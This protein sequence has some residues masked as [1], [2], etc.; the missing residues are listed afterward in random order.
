MA[1]TKYIK[2]PIVRS[3]ASYVDQELRKIE[4]AINSLAA[5]SGDTAPL[6]VKKTADTSRAST[7]TL[8]A[9]PDLVLTL[10]AGYWE[11]ETSLCFYTAGTGTSGV[12]GAKCLM[13]LNGTLVP[14]STATFPL[15]SMLWAGN[16]GGSSL[17]FECS[18]ETTPFASAAAQLTNNQPFILYAR[19][20][21]NVSVGGNLSI[22][23]AQLTSNAVATKLA[24]GSYLRAIQ[25]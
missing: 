5:G 17:P 1:L 21:V 20:A 16:A 14:A 22:Y 24:A 15:R 9:D 8:A 18:A 25:I 10:T 23:W 11:V 3:L 2:S 4:T 7:A 19:G 13:Y 6:F 12:P